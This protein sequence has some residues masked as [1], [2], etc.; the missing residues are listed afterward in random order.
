MAT[1]NNFTFGVDA[2]PFTLNFPFIDEDN[3]VVTLDGVVKTLDTDYTVINKT[4]NTAAGVGFLSGAQ[5]QFTASPLP[6]AGAVKVVRNT[7]LETTSTFKTGSAIRAI[8]LNSNF[9]QNLYVTEEISNNAILTDGSNAFDGDF[10]MGGN[11]ITNLGTPATD[12]DAANK[13]YVDTRTGSST[14]PGFTRWRATATD[15]Q[16]LFS[17]VGSTGVTLAYS[18]ARENVYVNGA[19]QQR[20]IDYTADNGTSVTFLVGLTAGDIV[21]VLCV[22]NTPDG[23]VPEPL[24]DFLNKATIASQTVTGPVTFNSNIQTG[25]ALLVGT[26]STALAKI[27]V[28]AENATVDRN[29][30]IDFVAQAA[31]SPLY[32]LRLARFADANSTLTHRGT[33]NLDIVAEEAG[34]IRFFVNGLKPLDIDPFNAVTVSNDFRVGND[35][36]SDV[37]IEVGAGTTGNRNAYIDFVGDA[38]YSDYGFRVIRGNTG[39]NADSVLG[40]RGTGS[41]VLNTEDAGGSILL[42]TQGVSRVTIDSNGRIDISSRV[43]ITNDDD[44]L[45]VTSDSYNGTTFP[46]L[47]QTYVD[48]T[49]GNVVF[50]RVNVTDPTESAAVLLKNNNVTTIVNNQTATETYIGGGSTPEFRV[51]S[52]VNGSGNVPVVAATD[53]TLQLGTVAGFIRSSTNVSKTIAIN[54]HVTVTASGQTITLPTGSDGD[55]VRISVGSFTDTIVS[56]AQNIMASASDLT[57]DVALKTVTLM[58]DNNQDGGLSVVGWRII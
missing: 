17:G 5:I 56:S 41:L 30:F 6:T 44:G 8:D 51:T 19:L 50:N 36:T 49:N 20:N 26:D 27:E 14:I 21:E 42:N 37:R 22:N 39:P 29:T 38:T 45:L 9:T 18:V 10:N 31:T 48:S 34:R 58:Y 4:S 47:A 3:L 11:Q 16:T 33:G 2:H 15:A 32:G 53:G 52:L 28:G 23:T 24:D 55:T 54:E 40:H 1:T 25:N 35:F 13:V 12:S 57:I 43:A 46:W 7:T